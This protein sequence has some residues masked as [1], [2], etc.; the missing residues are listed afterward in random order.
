MDRLSASE[1]VSATARVVVNP[2]LAAPRWAA[3]AGTIIGVDA[4][5]APIVQLDRDGGY[6]AGMAVVFCW[7]E[8]TRIASAPDPHVVN[9]RDPF[10][11]RPWGI[12]LHLPFDGV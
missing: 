5:G 9:D 4:S 2:D 10:G 12:G 6:H 7:Y 1:S 8:L 3:R 11:A